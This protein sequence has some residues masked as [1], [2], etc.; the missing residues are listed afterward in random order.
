LIDAR[1]LAA[2]NKDLKQAISDGKFREDLYYRLGVVTIQLPPLRER[3]EDVL[4]LA[5]ALLQRYAGENRK[6]ITGFTKQAIRAIEEHNWPG[7]IR[8]LENRI[9]RAVIM[10]EGSKIAPEYLELASPYKKYE[11]G[12]ERSGCR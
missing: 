6:K 12:V 3:E 8:E 2:T 9:K 11:V 1:V 4:V 5:T 7:N 10:A